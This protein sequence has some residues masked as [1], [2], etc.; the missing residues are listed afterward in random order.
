MSYGITPY[1]IEERDIKKYVIG[2]KD[3]SRISFTLKYQKSFYSQLNGL[4]EGRK[5]ISAEDAVREILYGKI[6]RRESISGAIY[7]YV[8]EKLCE[9]FDIVIELPNRDFYPIENEVIRKIFELYTVYPTKWQIFKRPLMGQSS[10][11][12][13][14]PQPEDFPLV[15][16]IPNEHVKKL[17]RDF[18]TLELPETCN[19]EFKGWLD[20]TIKRDEF[21][22]ALIL[23]Y[24]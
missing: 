22:G 3:E 18:S 1:Y 14:F 19:E 7:W 6:T 23:Y 5:C 4:M 16:Y 20:F 8:F 11:S 17:R 9:R 21:E 2:T 15:A 10:L 12:I 13:P 24:Y